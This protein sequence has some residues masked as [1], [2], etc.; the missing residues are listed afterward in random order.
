MNKNTVYYKWTQKGSYYTS[1]NSL[2]PFFNNTNFNVIF[3][4]LSTDKNMDS[5]DNINN[6]TSKS[7]SGNVNK[8]CLLLCS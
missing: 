1:L 4:D 6:K 7:K 8:V 3:D 2:K 5:D